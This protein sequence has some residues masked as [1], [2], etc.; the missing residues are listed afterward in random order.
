MSKNEKELSDRVI[1]W[2]SDIYETNTGETPL[3]VLGIDG[4]PPSLSNSFL[5]DLILGQ[6]EGRLLL[7]SGK[8]LG[9][10]VYTDK[11][12]GMLKTFRI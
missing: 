11:E 2:V 5:Y 9:F 8:T 10:L 12:G 6:F 4:K 3:Q 1:A 7:N